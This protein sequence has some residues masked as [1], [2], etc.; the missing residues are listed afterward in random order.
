M[1]N[2]TH[3]SRLSIADVEKAIKAYEE[4]IAEAM[5]TGGKVISIDFGT[6]DVKQ[7]AARNVR[8]PQTGKSMIIPT[9]QTLR[10]R[11]GK[12]LELK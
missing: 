11:P 3:A 12:N 6:F 2:K 1:L 9:K 5:N 8:N 10:F 7:V 4:A